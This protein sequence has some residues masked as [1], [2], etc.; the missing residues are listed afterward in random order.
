[1]IDLKPIFDAELQTFRT[2]HRE[3]GISNAIGQTSDLAFTEFR[4]MVGSIPTD[5]LAQFTPEQ[6]DQQ[7]HT[8][9]RYAI[10][11]WCLKWGLRKRK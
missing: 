4:D 11:S 2:S 5:H 1:M 10:T 9:A 3:R 8:A 6:I 7:F